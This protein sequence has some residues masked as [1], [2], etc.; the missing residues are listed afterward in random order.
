[1]TMDRKRLDKLYA[2]HLALA[3][4]PTLALSAGAV[5]KILRRLGNPPLTAGHGGSI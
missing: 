3:V 4:T 2:S 1:M 5:V